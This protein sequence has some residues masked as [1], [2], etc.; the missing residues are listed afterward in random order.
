MPT[1]E[2][3]CT[4]CGHRFEAVHSMTADPLTVCPEC[5]GQLRKVLHAAGIVFKGSG[6]YATDSRSKPTTDGATKEKEKTGAGG[7]DPQKKEPQ[8]KEPSTKGTGEGGSSTSESTGSKP[9]D[10]KGS[11]G[12]KTSSGKGKDGG[13]S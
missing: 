2:Y 8:K 7:K 12:A 3:A 5:G 9:S 11:G 13:G 10:P 6:F 4:A 1:Y